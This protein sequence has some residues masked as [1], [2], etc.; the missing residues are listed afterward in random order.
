MR[1]QTRA[2]DPVLE[3]LNMKKLVAAMAMVAAVVLCAG[4]AMLGAYGSR[5]GA[6]APS[7]SAR[8]LAAQPTDACALLTTAQVSAALGAAVEA[9]LHVVPNGTAICV[10]RVPG[11]KD[12]KRV[13]LDIYTQIGS[14]T[15]AQRFNNA[16]MPIAVKGI[17]KE[18]V[19]GV[20]DDAVSVTTQGIGTG[21]IFRKGASAFDLRV[22]GFPADQVKAKEKTLALDVIAKL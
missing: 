13:M 6:V 18:P 3:V 4:G 1:P 21:L 2:L 8:A 11:D 20:G 16:K 5:A 15:P 22:Y 19:S 17:T 7:R 12:H 14:L 10:W 9:G